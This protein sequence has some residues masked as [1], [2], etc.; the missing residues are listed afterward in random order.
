MKSVLFTYKIGKDDQEQ[1]A[2]AK[3]LERMGYQVYFEKESSFEYKPYMKD[4]EILVC[5][6][7]FKKLNIDD[8]PALKWIQLTSMGFEQVP[9]QQV[10]DRGIIV[11]NNRGGYSIPMGEWVVLNILELI[12][13]RKA[14]Y[15][16]QAKKNWSM[17]F[18]ITELYKKKVA[19][20]GTGDIARESVK[21]LQGFE[22]EILGVNT[23]GRSV[24]GFDQCFPM[25]ALGNV[26]RQSDVV[27][28]CLPH[29]EE[30]E[31]IL[32]KAMLDQMKKDA[33]LINVS[34]GAI[35]NEQDLIQHLIEGKLKGVALDVFE[36]EP[37]P[38]ESK[39][40][41]FDRVVVTAHNSWVSEEIEERRWALILG[42]LENYKE[43]KQLQ[44]VV[45]MSKGY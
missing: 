36:K 5:Y 10:T 35:I 23:N 26:L 15:N 22:V 29:T 8:F 13:N 12:K 43:G 34:R 21:R 2:R 6:Q 31:H 28:S 24:D 1:E 32:N 37:L 45:E 7:V 27:I 42:N 19:F 14:A 3:H 25:S 16:H 20:I 4:V 39:L 33:S 9:E 41:A 11:T 40:W 18:S 38:K 44:N 30:T 17:D